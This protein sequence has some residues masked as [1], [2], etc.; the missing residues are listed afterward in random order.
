MCG[1]AVIVVI[2]RLVCICLV[3]TVL[4]RFVECVLPGCVVVIVCACVCI[5]WM[6]Y[7]GLIVFG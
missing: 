4:E 3:S 5:G 2:C 1:S 6:W 7:V